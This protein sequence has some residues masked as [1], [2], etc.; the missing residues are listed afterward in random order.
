MGSE[1]IH[2]IGGDPGPEGVGTGECLRLAYLYALIGWFGTHPQ[3]S[4]WIPVLGLDHARMPH[5]RLA[6]GG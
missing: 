3:P 6:S 1:G 2:G 5:S 4:V